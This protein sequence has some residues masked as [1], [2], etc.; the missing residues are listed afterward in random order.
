M[1]TEVGYRCPA[2]INRQ[3]QAFYAE[4]RPLDYLVASLV[5]LP[6]SLICGWIVPAL[7]W[8]T[9]FL[10]PL[11]GA[12]IAEAA[13]RAIGRRRGQYTWLVV[14]GC[15]LVGGLP[16][17]LFTLLPLLLIEPNGNILPTGAWSLLWNGV[18]W[19]TAVGSAIARLR[20][21]RLH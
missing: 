15:V 20:S 3:Q 14:G 16:I 1:R 8:F 19:V 13:H 2:C 5:A 11:A 12:G 9:L 17:V 18:Y 21:S 7:G 4:F 6:L 10:G